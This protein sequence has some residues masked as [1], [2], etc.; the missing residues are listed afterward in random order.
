[1]P[2]AA[3]SRCLTITPS[4]ARGEYSQT[5]G[6]KSD[7]GQ[8][9]GHDFATL[10]QQRRCQRHIKPQRQIKR[11]GFGPEG[12]QPVNGGMRHGGDGKKRMFEHP[13]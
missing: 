3:T 9:V 1:M 6:T 2:D 13:E 10:N 8:C 4:S 12:N 7:G 11:Q 5:D